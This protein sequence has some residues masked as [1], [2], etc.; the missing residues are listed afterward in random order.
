MP[1]TM[2]PKERSQIS[3]SRDNIAMGKV[4]AQ[5]LLAVWPTVF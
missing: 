4:V 3:R 5:I 1:L 2:E